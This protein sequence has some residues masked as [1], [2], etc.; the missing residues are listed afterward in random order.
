MKKDAKEHESEDKKKKEEIDLK[1][2]ADSMIFQGE[3][4]LKEFESKLD[5][6]T[7][8]KIQGAIDRLKEANK[9]TNANELKSAIEQYNAAWN[10]ASQ[11]MYSQAKSQG[12]PG[13]DG[14]Q[15]FSGGQQSGF[16]G[17]Q[18]P[19]GASEQKKDDGKVENADFEVVDD[20]K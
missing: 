19:G 17:G 13:A 6:G 20:K 7:R 3:K 2:Q 5:Q 12:A 1:N 15:G 14:G 18:E 10:E 16:A 9:G 8:A 11:Q 4:Q